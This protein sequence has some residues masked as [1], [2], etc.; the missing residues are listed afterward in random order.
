M[1]KIKKGRMLK[2]TGKNKD[3]IYI[4]GNLRI[5]LKVISVHKYKKLGKEL[6]PQKKEHIIWKKGT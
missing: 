4:K 3:K 1:M 2:Q 5:K 6:N